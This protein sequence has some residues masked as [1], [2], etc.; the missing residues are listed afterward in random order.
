MQLEISGDVTKT[1]S[2]GHRPVRY[3]IRRPIRGS[4]PIQAEN[5]RAVKTLSGTYRSPSL[6]FNLLVSAGLST[7]ELDFF[8]MG[9]KGIASQNVTPDKRTMIQSVSYDF[10]SGNIALALEDGRVARGTFNGEVFNIS[11]PKMFE[12]TQTSVPP[13]LK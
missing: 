10:Y 7:N 3:P 1:Q 4:I 13:Y 8:P 6:R 2:S 9:V 12:T 5:T 11:W